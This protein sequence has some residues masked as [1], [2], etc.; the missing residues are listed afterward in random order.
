MK[1]YYSKAI[2]MQNEAYNPCL[3]TM[4]KLDQGNLNIR[5][6]LIQAE[7]INKDIPMMLEHLKSEEEYYEATGYVLELGASCGINF[8]Y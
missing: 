7:A 8:V 4:E 2:R 5:E 3:K 6:Y 1:T